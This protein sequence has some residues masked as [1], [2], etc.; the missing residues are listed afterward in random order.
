MCDICLTC[1][2]PPSSFLSGTTASWVLWWCARRQQ[3]RACLSL[4]LKD[5]WFWESGQSACRSSTACTRLSAPSPPTFF[6]RARCRT[7]SLQVCLKTLR[8]SFYSHG[9]RK[10]VKK[11]MRFSCRFQLIASRKASTSSGLSQINPCSS[12]WLRV[13][14]KLPA[15]EPPTLT[16]KVTSPFISRDVTT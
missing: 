4:C 14:R 7:V 10:A 6:M 3:R 15:L 11:T 12:M 16:G 5:W 9:L 1:T 2:L 13:R 8:G